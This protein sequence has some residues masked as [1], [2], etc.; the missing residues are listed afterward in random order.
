LLSLVK[1]KFRYAILM[2]IS[3]GIGPGKQVI[4]RMDF[5]PL[6]SPELKQMDAEIFAWRMHI[7]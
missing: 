6:I 7:D 5:R 4:A 2:K 3:P 1:Y